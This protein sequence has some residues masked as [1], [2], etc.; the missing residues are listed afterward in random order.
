MAILD[1]AQ[2]IK[3]C[4]TQIHQASLDV[5]AQNKLILSGTPIENS[6]SELWCLFNF[7]QPGLLGE[8]EYFEKEFCKQII[9]GGYTKANQ[10]EREMAKHMVGK[11]RDILK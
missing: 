4:G 8:K 6:L 1:E 3:N 11:L 7:V 2:K 9:R 5:R 10:V